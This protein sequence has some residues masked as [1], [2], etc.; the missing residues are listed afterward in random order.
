MKEKDIDELSE[1]INKLMDDIVFLKCEVE[2]IMNQITILFN[3]C[4]AK[5]Y[6]ILD[7]RNPYVSPNRIDLR[8]EGYSLSGFLGPDHEIWVKKDP[9]NL[10]MRH[11]SCTEN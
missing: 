6:K 7:F 3:C 11:M 1:T 10:C 9:Q 4:D 8:K 2:T 5:P